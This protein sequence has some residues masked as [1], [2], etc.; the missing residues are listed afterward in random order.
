MSKTAL[1]IM[2]KTKPGRRD[3]VRQVWEKHLRPQIGENA[4][5]EAYFYCYDDNDPDLICVFQ[6]YS[7]HTGPQEFVKQPW[8]SAYEKAVAPL[9]AGK[10][11]FRSATPFWIKSSSA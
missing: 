2:H 8:Y 1:F 10:S 5:H 7:D 9:L 3:E 11:E 6:L 4:V